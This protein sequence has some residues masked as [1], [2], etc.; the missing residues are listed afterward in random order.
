M[1]IA[2]LCQRHDLVICSDEIHCELLLDDTQHVPIASL[3]PTISARTITLL[4]PSKTY[5]IPALGCS[6][7]IVQNAELRGQLQKAATGIVPHVNVLGY[8]AA[9]AAYKECDE[10]LLAL[11]SYLTANRDFVVEYV[12]QHLPNI[13]VTVPEATYLAWLDCRESGIE[14]DPYQFFL[15]KAKVAL[16]DGARFGAEGEGFVRLNFGCARSTLQD[17]LD[18]MRD[19]L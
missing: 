4:A 10:W 11:R 15:N 8:A 1:Q 16:N 2:D 19:A 12:E 18:R 3:D 14:D 5:N 13:G 17:A 9:L 7:A 6:L